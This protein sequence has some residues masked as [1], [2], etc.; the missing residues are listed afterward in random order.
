MAVGAPSLGSRVQNSLINLNERGIIEHSQ[1]PVVSHSIANFRVCTKPWSGLQTP[2]RSRD[3]S[4]DHLHMRVSMSAWSSRSSGEPE[5]AVSRSPSSSLTTAA[6]A[7][8][9]AAGACTQPTPYIMKII[10]SQ[11]GVRCRIRCHH[12][13]Q[14]LGLKLILTEGISGTGFNTGVTGVLMLLQ[15]LCSSLSSCATRA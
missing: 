1:I 8:S 4:P 7:I 9:A 6:A 11:N 12:H 13:G 5:G 10:A 2:S 15:A 3:R 14:S